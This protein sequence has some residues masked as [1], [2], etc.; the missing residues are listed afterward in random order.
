MQVNKKP[1]NGVRNMNTDK[2][3][4]VIGSGISGT[5]A[6]WLLRERADVV[7]FEAESRFGGHTH[8]YQT[9][10]NGESVA[11]DTGFMVFNRPNYPLLTALFEHLEID[12]YPTEM[13]FSASFDDG[14]FEYAG[15]SLDTL[16]GQRRNLVSARFWGMLRDVLRFNRVAHRA[17]K[18]PLPAGTTVGKFLDDAGFAEE[19]RSRYLYP[20]AAAI[21]SCPHGQMAQFPAASFLRFFANHGLIQLAGR[22]QWRTVRGGSRRYMDR[23]I[24]DLGPRARAGSPVALVERAEAGVT[25]RLADGRSE[26]FDTVVMACHS[27]QALRLLSRPSPTERHLLGA[28]PYQPNRV[29]LH[30]DSALMPR[31]RRVWSSWNYRGAAGQEKERAVSVT[32]WMNSLQ[33]LP[34][35]DNYFVSLNPLHEPR[36]ELVAAEFE[37]HHPVFDADALR[38]QRQLHRIQGRGNTWF[39]GAWTGYGFHEDGIRSGVEVATALGAA[40]PWLDEVR[41]SRGLTLVPQLVGQPA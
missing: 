6:A 24:G 30:R 27:D 12:S 38:A 41:E 2:R 36:D 37:Y 7:L 19:F 15:T 9:G 13:S 22:P 16:F 3:I 25:L 14:R 1:T 39:A 4:A 18:H 26:V 21:W 31:E 40:V 11:V 29:I 23:L 8:T 10:V 28:I 33:H 35:R 17:L 5:V 20:M 34:T 32:Y